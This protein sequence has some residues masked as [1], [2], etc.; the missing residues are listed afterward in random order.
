MKDEVPRSPPP[1][2]SGHLGCNREI[3][4]KVAHLHSNIKTHADE[5]ALVHASVT[6]LTSKL[7]PL[8]KKTVMN[9]IKTGMQGTATK[10]G[11]LRKFF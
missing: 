3:A 8:I 10:K 1:S 7:G 6:A 5:S 2:P 9:D 4:D 11:E